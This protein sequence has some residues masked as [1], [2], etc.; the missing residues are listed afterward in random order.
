M[1]WRVFIGG[2]VAALAGLKILGVGILLMG[3]LLLWSGCTALVCSE[4]ERRVLA[5]FPQYGGAQVTPEGNI[6]TG[7]CAVYYDVSDPPDQVQSYFVEQLT[8]HGWTV[9]AVPPAGTLVQAQRG[10]FSYIVYSETIESYPGSGTHLAVHV[11][12]D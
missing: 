1:N 9:E 5:E 7:A 2:T 10:Q 3:M 6:D 12:Q 11:G 4:E 8:A